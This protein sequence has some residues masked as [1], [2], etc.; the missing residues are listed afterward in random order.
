MMK[1]QLVK[2]EEQ[3]MKHSVPITQTFLAYVGHYKKKNQLSS[4]TKT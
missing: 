4:L 2:S 3:L 1:E